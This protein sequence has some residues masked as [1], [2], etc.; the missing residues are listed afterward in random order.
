MQ[1][2]G[3]MNVYRSGHFHKAGKPGAFDR[4]AGDFYATEEAARADIAPRS[5][6]VA[7]VPISWPDDVIAANPVSE[8]QRRLGA[9]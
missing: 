6:Y 4:H 5:H 7:T 8:R 2:K 1:I 9:Q 3:W